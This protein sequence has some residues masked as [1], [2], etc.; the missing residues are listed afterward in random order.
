MA[1]AVPTRIGQVNGAGDALAMFLKVF[2]GEVMT[3]FRAACKTADKHRIRTITH[4]K[5]ATFPAI[6]IGTAD[7]HVAGAE[8]NGTT[9]NMAERVISI[10]GLLLADRFLASIDEAMNHFDVRGPLSEDVGRVLA[11]RWDKN[12][13]QKMVLAARAAATVTGLP[14]GSSVTSANALTVANDLYSAIRSAAQKLDENNIPEEGR[15][16]FLRP[17][18]YSLLLDAAK[19]VNRDYVAGANG[20]IDTGMVFQVN[21][22]AIVKTNNT[23]R[24]NI[25]TGLATYQGDFTN[26][27]GPVV[28]TSAVGTVKLL[29]LAVESEYQIQRQGWLLVAKYAMGTDILRPESAVEIKTA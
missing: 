18:Q 21:G 23:P 13:L 14:G 2:G 3:A 1:N 16:C 9:V 28:H 20:G 26:T 19:V 4:G 15:F 29:D 27:V 12:V 17:A 7:Y 10:D 5:S 8:V 25:N 22:V 11:D 6:G 24:T